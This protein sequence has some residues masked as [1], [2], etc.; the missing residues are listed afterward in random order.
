MFRF[1]ASSTI[2]KL[3]LPWLIVELFAAF[4]FVREHGLLNLVLEV[5][6]SGILGIFCMS[7]VGFFRFFSN[8]TFLRLRDIF[9]VFGMAVGGFLL[10]IPGLVSDLVGLIAVIVA[11]FMRRNTQNNTENFTYFGFEE[12]IK[13]DFN[14]QN[15][16]FYRY[17]EDL[18]GYGRKNKEADGEIIDVEVIEET[19]SVR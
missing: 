16:G 18:R 6:F 15:G 4:L 9:G 12:H 5:V 19:K 10:F 11:L 13:D 17:K 1:V 14:S 7:Q 3:F 8:A 2:N